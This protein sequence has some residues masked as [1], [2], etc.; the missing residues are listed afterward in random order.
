MITVPTCEPCNN[1]AKLDDEYFRACIA[2][3]GTPGTKQGELWKEKFVDSTLARSPAL[4]AAI[5]QDRQRIIEFHRLT[6]LKTFD[7]RI[8]PAELIDLVLPFDASRINRVLVKIVR[9]LYYHHYRDVMPRST[10]FVVTRRLLKS[11]A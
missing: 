10:H 9:G 11:V 2:T 7:G 1:G 5:L 3:G 8:L 4:K 6:P